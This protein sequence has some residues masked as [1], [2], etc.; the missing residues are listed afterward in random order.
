[1][2]TDDPYS[3]DSLRLKLNHALGYTLVRPLPATTSTNDDVAPA[4]TAA[5]VLVRN[6]ARP[7]VR[8]VPLPSIDAG[9]DIQRRMALVDQLWALTAEE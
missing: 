7:D 2:R 9:E 6:D 5:R 8:S 3:T 4:A 1:M